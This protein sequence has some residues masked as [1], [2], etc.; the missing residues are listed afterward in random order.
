M[1]N[2]NQISCIWTRIQEISEIHF[3]VYLQVCLTKPWKLQKGVVLTRFESF[4]E[5]LTLREI[6]TV[7]QIGVS[8]YQFPKM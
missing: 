4:D 3:I 2:Q 6:R 1:R 8:F 7:A 5:F